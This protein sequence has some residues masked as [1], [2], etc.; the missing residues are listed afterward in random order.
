M[1]GNR[2]ASCYGSREQKKKKKRAACVTRQTCNLLGGQFVPASWLNYE[3][4]HQ[5]LLSFV[6]D[7]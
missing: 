5:E 7:L 4:K 3:L 1:E 6:Y 2:F